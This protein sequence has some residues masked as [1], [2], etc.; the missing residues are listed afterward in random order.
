MA[1]VSSIGRVAT[2]DVVWY[3]SGT[4]R[5]AEAERYAAAAGG[6]VV[7]GDA[8]RAVA[9]KLRRGG[10]SGPI[11][12]D[13]AAYERPGR[14]PDDTLFGDRWGLVQDHLEVAER[15]SPGA[16]VPADEGDLLRD[17]VARESAWLSD[18]GGGRLSLCL[19]W[20]WLTTDTG[21]VVD[22]LGRA[23]A[24]VA[25]SL[26]AGDDPLG[27]RLPDVMLLRSD[28]GALGAVAH[29]AS[30]GAFGTST[31]VR[32]YVPPATSPGGARRDRTPS[33]FLP[34]LL[35]FKLGSFCDQ[36]PRDAVPMCDL[37]CCD[38]AHLSRFNDEHMTA[39]A[40]AHNRHVVQAVISTLRDSPAPERAARFHSMCREA[41]QATAALE[42][43]AR[44]TIRRAP[45]L[46]A[47]AAL[48][49]PV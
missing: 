44:R 34:A 29:G 3:V 36:L 20:R 25:L 24:P 19:H 23:A 12:L 22:Q 13:P 9:G 5:P 33:V 17:A 42:V 39:E 14:E 1:G 11:W 48:S 8:G 26:A 47:W 41:I 31:G 35:G 46:L 40:R 16:Y 38:G 2:S 15:I 43:A 37:P 49:P 18:A 21:A 6:V 7:R 10:W 32:H 28:L 30:L 4:V 27:H 45:Q